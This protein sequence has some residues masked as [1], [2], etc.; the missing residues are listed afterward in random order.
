MP[1]LF[2]T[3]LGEGFN[4]V[5][6]PKGSTGVQPHVSGRETRLGY[7]TFPMHEWDLTFNVLHDFKQWPT[8]PLQIPSELK[9]LEGFFMAMQGSLIPFYFM[10]PDDNAVLATQIGMG[11]GVRTTF[12][13]TR[14][15]GDPSYGVT[16]TEPVG[17][18]DTSTFKVY[19]NGILQS[20]GYNLPTT[21]PY[22][23]VFSSAPGAGVVITADLPTFFFL[24]R[25]KEDTLDFEKFSGAPG[26]G[27]WAVKKLTLMSLRP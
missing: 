26:A 12:L 13:I 11:D 18:Y 2:P 21:T 19:L 10:D 25:F 1:L 24:V 15:F 9:R 22:T 17:G 23:V 20:S 16:V 5:R 6:R 27:Y 14:T 7:W 8:A 3:F 4:V